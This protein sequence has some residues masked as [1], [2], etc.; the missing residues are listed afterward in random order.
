MTL[1]DARGE[2][3]HDVVRVDNLTVSCLIGVHPPERI[4]R[5]PLVVSLALHLDTRRAAFD[6]QLAH[7]ADYAR[8]VGEVRFVLERG[9]FHLLETAAEV[10]ARVV[11]AAAGVVADVDV[12]LQKPAALGGAA[13]PSLTIHRDREAASAVWTYAFGTVDVVWNHNGLGVYRLALKPKASLHVPAHVGCF[14]V[15]AA[16]AV[17]VAGPLTNADATPREYLLLARPPLRLD[18][19]VTA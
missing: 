3:R 13:V 6:E 16:A 4:T 9:D 14:D 5:Q 10:V 8:I 11:L 12:T 2:R 18:A 17:N 19:F 7:T 15:D 1:V